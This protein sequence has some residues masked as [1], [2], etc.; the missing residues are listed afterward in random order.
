MRKAGVLKRTVLDAGFL[1]RLV[2]FQ[3]SHSRIGMK[4]DA[5]TGRYCE[6]VAGV[7]LLEMR[8][9]VLYVLE[10]ILYL[11]HADRRSSGLRCDRYT[12]LNVKRAGWFIEFY[13]F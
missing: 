8:D 13:I 1:H 12:D 2:E 6:R 9:I 4:H 3:V 10:V 7:I 5:P 11:Q